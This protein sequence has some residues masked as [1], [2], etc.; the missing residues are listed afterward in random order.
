MRKWIILSFFTGF[1][2]GGAAAFLALP[3]KS[4]LVVDEQPEKQAPQDEINADAQVLEAEE[5]PPTLSDEDLEAPLP[6]ITD[7][8]SGK[9]APFSAPDPNPEDGRD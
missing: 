7:D 5:I 9:P 3:V 4:P 8:D 6:A 1:I 2:L